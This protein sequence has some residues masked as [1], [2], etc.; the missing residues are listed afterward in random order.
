MTGRKLF[1][2]RL[3]DDIKYQRKI[4]GMFIDWTVWF[5]A[6]IPFLIFGVLFYIDI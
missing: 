4:L 6:F 2:L 1:K 5:Y 3:I